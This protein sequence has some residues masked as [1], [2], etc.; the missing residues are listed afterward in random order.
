MTRRL[1]DFW[2]LMSTSVPKFRLIVET[3]TMSPSL[4]WMVYCDTAEED[5]ASCSDIVAMALSS[6]SS[7][8]VFVT[9]EMASC[10]AAR[11]ECQ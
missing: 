2:S 5:G 8:Y 4:F 6:Q 1:P 7:T 3:A 11:R 9:V 10:F